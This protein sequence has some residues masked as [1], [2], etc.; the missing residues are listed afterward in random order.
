VL[1]GPHKP[2]QGLDHVTLSDVLEQLQYGEL[3]FLK[4]GELD[5]DE[6]RKKVISHISLGLTDLHKRFWLRSKD[7][8]INIL[9]GIRDYVLSSKYNLTNLD[10]IYTK[11]IVDTAEQPFQDDLLRIER[12]FNELG[13][14][15]Y[16]ND[17]YRDDSFYTPAYNRLRVP[18]SYTGSKVLLEY[19]ANHQ[20]LNPDCDA[21]DIDLDLPPPLLEPLLLFVAHRAT[22]SLNTDQNAESTQYFQMY[23]LACNNVMNKSF[24]IV[25]ERTN[26]KLD[27]GG[28]V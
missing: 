14:E 26:I 2:Q 25:P 7:I 3:A 1:R 6:E 23:E 19:R 15:Q 28:W 5:T 22:R 18:I 9:P 17:D 24:Q 8:T 4:L 27:V 21:C 11:Y 16:L 10:T 20:K 12:V 13:E